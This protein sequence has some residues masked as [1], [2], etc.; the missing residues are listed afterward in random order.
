M[1]TEIAWEAL[2]DDLQR[3]LQA[4]IDGH[5]RETGDDHAH[6]P[7]SMDWDKY[8]SL[9]RMAMFKAL[10]ARRDSVLVGYVGFFITPHMMYSKTVHALCDSIYVRPEHRGVGIL[11][12]REAQ[13]KLTELVGN[14]TF[15][16]I[17]NAPAGSEFAQIL[18]RFGY[19]VRET[20]H[21]KLVT[22][23]DA[24]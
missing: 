24:T 2:N 21:V 4:I 9:E 18:S 13:K 7:L 5:W 16:I 12:V 23:H 10:I 1:R 14:K 6:V 19:P 3:D 17:Y 22:A 20:T 8:R 15:R 11:L